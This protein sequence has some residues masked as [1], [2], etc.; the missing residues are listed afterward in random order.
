VSTLGIPAPVRR[1]RDAVLPQSRAL[2]AERSAPATLRVRSVTKTFHGAGG[3]VTALDDVSVEVQ[4]GE[5]VCLVG[6]SG[7]G[8][9]TLLNLI[10]GLDH[11][12]QGQLMLGGQA[13]ERPGADRVVMFQEPALFPWLNV[14]DNVAFGLTLSGMRRAQRYARAEQYLELVGLGQF[15]RAWVHE[16]SGGMKGRVALARALVLDPRVLLMDEP[17]AALD[18]QTRDRLLLEL[19]RIWLETGKTIVFVTHNVREAAVLANRV[20]VFSA[21]P[22]RIKAEIHID[23]PR[24]RELKSPEMLAAANRISAELESEVT[25][26]EEQE[27]ATATAR[28]FASHGLLWRL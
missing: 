17:F 10:A 2:P 13:I 21:R 28:N 15:G 19:Q 8:K 3:L 25:I 9:S 7:C 14:R 11:P 18:A 23:V 4:P 27:M 1:W 22:G 12:S 26:S 6:P 24:P 16:L 20:L 5:F